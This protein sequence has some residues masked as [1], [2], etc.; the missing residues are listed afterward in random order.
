M[1]NFN[2]G[3]MEMTSKGRGKRMLREDVIAEQNRLQSSLAEW[4][5]HQEEGR[6]LITR[7]QTMILE[8]QR[9][10]DI[11][12]GHLERLDWVLERLEPQDECPTPE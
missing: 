7:G 2:L 11:H 4:S 3:G 9:Q 5:R 10:I 6:S 8:A 1:G 12:T